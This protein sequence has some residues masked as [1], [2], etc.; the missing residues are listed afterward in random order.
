MFDPQPTGLADWLATIDIPAT[1][2]LVIGAVVALVGADVLARRLTMR[3]A[4]RARI[5]AR[6]WGEHR[7][8]A[9]RRRARIRARTRAVARSFMDTPAARRAI[10]AVLAVTAV[11][12]TV[13]S[14]HGV[15][16]ALTG[17]GLTAWWTRLAGLVAF[18][19][20]LLVMASLSWWH[21]TTGQDGADVY[22]TLVWGGAGVLALV[23]YH[24][25]DDWLYAVFAPLAALG[26]HLV[27]GA[28]RRRRNA[29]TTWA[30]RIGA[31]I[32]SRVERVLVWFGRTPTSEDTNARERERRYSRVVARTVKAHRANRAKS[33]RVWLFER[34]LADAEARGL[35]DEAGRALIAER[36]AAR[37]TALDALA[38]ATLAVG[39]PLWTREAA[40]AAPL[41]PVPDPKAPPAPASPAVACELPEPTPALPAPD[42]VREAP[43]APVR[44]IRPAEAASA[45][46]VIVAAFPPKAA[47]GAATWCADYYDEH[48]KLPTGREVGDAFATHQG[49]A[50]KWLAPVRAVLDAA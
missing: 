5:R 14:A 44:P 4:A 41:A 15:Q 9:A 40:P 12:A 45:R 11:S 28:E 18:E 25:G 16:D 6:Q 37:Y 21:R 26:F 1:I 27:T 36:C 30:A 29:G 24:G 20:F 7:A 50:R 19:G 10:L 42:P 8:A 2:A 23:G 17:A 43:L 48:G 35:L 39:A 49:N 31:A 38:P 33:W 3:A 46:E 47:A 13:L 22:G 34:A 32:R